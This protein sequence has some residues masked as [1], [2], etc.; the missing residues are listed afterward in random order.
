MSVLGNAIVSINRSAHRSRKPGICK[1]KLEIKNQI[2]DHL[3]QQKRLRPVKRQSVNGRECIVLQLDDTDYSFHCP[4]DKLPSS[5]KWENYSLD[6]LQNAELKE[7]DFS[8]LPKEEP[9]EKEKWSKPEIPYTVAVRTVEQC[10]GVKLKRVVKLT[11]PKCQEQWRHDAL[12]K[13]QPKERVCPDC[14]E[15][16]IPTFR[17]CGESGHMSYEC[18]EYCGMDDDYDDDYDD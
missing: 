5:L 1:A 8:G 18:D 7:K 14:Y 10:I 17:N 9:L 11:C 15:R 3:S 16:R 2:I 12:N 4:V 6:N 13:G